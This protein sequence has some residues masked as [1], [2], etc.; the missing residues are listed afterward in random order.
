MHDERERERV[1]PHEFNELTANNVLDEIDGLVIRILDLAKDEHLEEDVT[2]SV[3]VGGRAE[4]H[5]IW[6]ISWVYL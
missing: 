2:M 4:I 3:W 6:E 5:T 1:P